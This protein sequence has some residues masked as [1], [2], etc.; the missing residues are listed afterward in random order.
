MNKSTTVAVFMGFCILMELS[1][2]SFTK[3]G[4]SLVTITQ[5]LEES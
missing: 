1:R 2:D 5:Q 3:E 4:G